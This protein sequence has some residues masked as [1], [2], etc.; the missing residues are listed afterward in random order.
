MS[1]KQRV[2]GKGADIFFSDDQTEK[3]EETSEQRSEDLVTK[4]TFYFTQSQLDNLEKAVFVLSQEHRIK[5]NKSEIMRI[6]CEEITK[7]FMEKSTDSK[8]YERLAGT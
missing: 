5:T 2:K 6:A 3:K 1:K 7:D 4:A 8:L